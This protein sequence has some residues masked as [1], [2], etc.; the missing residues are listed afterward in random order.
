MAQDNNIEAIFY[1]T[2]ITLDLAGPEGNV[3]YIMGLCKKLFCQLDIADEWPRY[4]N[5]C[6]KGYYK[7]VL[8]ISR[9]W[10]GFNYIN[11]PFR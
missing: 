7:D 5:E 3:F 10:F 6:R 8:A 9:R 1:P 4:Y 2:D 11:A